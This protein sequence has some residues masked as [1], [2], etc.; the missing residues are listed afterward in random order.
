[1]LKSSL[2]PT[3]TSAAFA[4]VRPAMGLSVLTVGRGEPLRVG[5]MDRNVFWVGATAVTF[6][7]RA[8]VLEVASVDGGSTSYVALDPNGGAP[9]LERVSTIRVGEASA[10]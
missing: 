2:C 10:R 4:T 6:A 1:M 7:A 5:Q 9:R 3:L 8:A